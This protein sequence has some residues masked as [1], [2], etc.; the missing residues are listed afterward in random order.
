MPRLTRAKNSKKVACMPTFMQNAKELPKALARRCAEQVA[1][2]RRII[3]E[4][5]YEVASPADAREM[6]ALKG[7]DKVRF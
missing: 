3:E 1:K 2:V 5:G 6:L 4:L 7:D